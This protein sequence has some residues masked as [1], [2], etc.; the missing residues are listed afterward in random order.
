LEGILRPI[1]NLTIKLNGPPLNLLV[2]ITGERLVIPGGRVFLGPDALAS[3]PN[4]PN[5][6][7]YEDGISSLF[8]LPDKIE[9]AALALWSIPLST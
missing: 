2:E 5:T 3:A 7:G 1:F 8:L 4:M 6:P 9:D